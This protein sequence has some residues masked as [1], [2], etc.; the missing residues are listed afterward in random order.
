MAAKLIRLTHKI[1]IQLHLMAESCTIWSSRSR[2]PV[3]KLLNIPSYIALYR[4]QPLLT[5]IRVLHIF[6]LVFGFPSVFKFRLFPVLISH[7]DAVTVCGVWYEKWMIHCK[8][9]HTFTLCQLSYWF[10]SW[11]HI[12]VEEK[13]SFVLSVMIPASLS[14]FESWCLDSSLQRRYSWKKIHCVVM[15]FLLLQ[16][17]E[18]SLLIT[19]TTFFTRV[20]RYPCDTVSVCS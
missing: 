11:Q 19:L 9:M 12:C 2:R 20:G 17:Y 14:W 15:R 1:A 6:C 10:L 18:R 4:Q 3:R 5:V 16:V 7:S 13:R 8:L